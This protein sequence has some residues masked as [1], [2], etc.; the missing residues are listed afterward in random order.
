M[1]NNLTSLIDVFYPPFKRLM[2]IQTFRYAACGGGNTVLGLAVYFVCLHYIFAHENFDAHFMIIKP[3]NASLI[4][5]SFVTLIVGFLLNKYL[6][7]TSSFLRGRVQFIRYLMS[8]AFNFFLNYLLL[9]LFVQKLHLEKFLAQIISIA[10]VISFSYFTQK[11]FTF[12][13]ERKDS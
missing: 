4:V 9:N 6:V 2:P 5:S 1:K 7:F 8:F 11:H 13:E 10:I 12:K 3:E